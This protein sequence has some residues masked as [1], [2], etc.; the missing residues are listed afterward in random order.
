VRILS[1][2]SAI[3]RTCLYLGTEGTGGKMFVDRVSTSIV[4]CIPVQRMRCCGPVKGQQRAVDDV[5]GALKIL[6]CCA[7]GGLGARSVVQEVD[8]WCKTVRGTPRSRVV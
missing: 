4:A 1:D 5:A 7:H 8:E 2:G 3:C 6:Q